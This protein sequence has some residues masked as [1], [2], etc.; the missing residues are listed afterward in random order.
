[1]HK[2]LTILNLV[3]VA[4]FL[5]IYLVYIFNIR[6]GIIDVVREMFTIPAML[7]QLVLIVMGVISIVKRKSNTMFIV[8]LVLLIM[9]TILTIGSFFVTI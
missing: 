3:T 5:F 9:C 8:S 7:G 4:Y 6:N 2:T 1:M